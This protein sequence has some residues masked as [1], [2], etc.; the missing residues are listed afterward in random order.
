[1]GS[2]CADVP[3][4]LKALANALAR[5]NM[6]KNMQVRPSGWVPAVKVSRSKK[7]C[8]LL[9]D[10]PV[11][12]LV[13]VMKPACRPMLPCCPHSVSQVIAKTKVPICKFEDAESGYN[14]DISFDVA[15]GPEVGLA[16]LRMSC[17]DNLGGA[18]DQNAP[19]CCAGT[20]PEPAGRREC[21]GADGCAA[22]DAAAGDGAQGL[23]AAAG[24][25]RGGVGCWTTHHTVTVLSYFARIHHPTTPDAACRPDRSTLAGWAAM[26]CSSWWPHSCSCTPRASRQ[27]TAA[28]IHAACCHV[29]LVVLAWLIGWPASAAGSGFVRAAEP[30]LGAV[31]CSQRAPLRQQQGPGGRQGAGGLLGRAARRLPA[32]V[33]PGTEQ[34][35]GG[36]GCDVADLQLSGCGLELAWIASIVGVVCCAGRRQLPQGR[37]VLQQARQG[38]LPGARE[39]TDSSTHRRLLCLVAGPF[40]AHTCAALAWDLDCQATE[41]CHSCPQPDRPFLYSVEDPNDP[42]NDLGRNSYNISRV[43]GMGSLFLGGLFAMHAPG[44]RA[45]ETSRRAVLA[46]CSEAP[47]LTCCLPCLPQVR[48]AFDWAYC[49]IIAP[50][51][52]GT[53]LLQRVIR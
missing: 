38:L 19:L 43:R 52:L 11:G 10:S 34:C 41:S 27:V 23:P 25:E 8:V 51:E 33:W 49:Q 47:S 37:L 24:A 4:G 40:E 36:R 35:G 22:A 48:M 13:W 53:S 32:L 15:N 46:A 45:W 5:K 17:G 31:C 2:G 14:F 50:A 6:A 29:F 30:V 28:A 16:G 18:H 20:L 44:W 42:T 9:A 39:N 26:R 3:Q 7:R 1:M 21:A 12:S